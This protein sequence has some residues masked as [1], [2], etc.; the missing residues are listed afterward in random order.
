MHKEGGCGAHLRVD[1]GSH[2]EDM[3]GGWEMEEF[4]IE[5]KEA[6]VQGRKNDQY[7]LFFFFFFLIDLTQIIECLPGF[8]HVPTSMVS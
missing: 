2:E 1:S 6:H 3:A 5:A 8:S 4:I 7:L